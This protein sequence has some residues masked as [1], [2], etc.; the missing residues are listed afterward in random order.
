MNSMDRRNFLKT[1]V[2]G[3]VAAT[4]YK[5]L[6]NIPSYRSQEQMPSS[7]AITTGD[8]RADMTFR[9]L[10]PFADQVKQAIGNRRVVLKPNMVSISIPLCAT[11]ADTLEGVLEFLKSID[12]L[13][14]VIIAESA[15]NGPTFDGYK[16]Y[17]YY[18][19]ADKYPV[20]MVDLDREGYEMRYVFDEKDFRPH[21]IRVSKVILSPDSYII[22][23]ARFKTHDRSVVTLSLKNIVFGAPIKDLGYTFGRD[24][25][26]GAIS[27]KPI[28]HGSGYRGINYNLYALASELHPD[29]AVI[30]GFQGME[31][32]GPMFG[33]PVDHR[34]CVVSTDWFSADRVAVELMGV[35]Y[36]KV[37]YMNYCAQTGLGD[38][39]L[40]KIEIIG[41]SISNHIKPYKL[42][43]NMDEQLIWMKP[44]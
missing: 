9:A 44:A 2:M 20:K 7:V 32:N 14:N 17:G 29:L 16:N 24:S 11:H 31:G 40:N 5:P 26:P 22:S 27:Y 41:E 18:R 23:T 13:D 43:D 28:V 36:A 25:R 37:G 19:L 35:D 4:F 12:K 6:R 42:A 15:A 39:D 38:P 30:D 34:V 3:G 8:N 21:P 1:S 33:T 10:R